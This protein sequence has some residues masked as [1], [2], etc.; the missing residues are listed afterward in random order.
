MAIEK[1]QKV[2]MVNGNMVGKCR[3]K[4]GLIKYG[5]KNM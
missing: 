4:D 2:M 1:W 5:D 3:W